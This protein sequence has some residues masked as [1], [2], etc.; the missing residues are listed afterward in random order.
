MGPMSNHIMREIMRAQCADRNLD[1]FDTMESEK[2]I[3]MFTE[4]AG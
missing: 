2:C 1:L 4:Y 3:V